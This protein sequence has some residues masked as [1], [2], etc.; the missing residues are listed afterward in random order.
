MNNLH[1]T[2]DMHSCDNDDKTNAIDD[3][4]DSDIHSLL[5]HDDENCPYAEEIKQAITESKLMCEETRIL[6]DSLKKLSENFVDTLRN[7]LKIVKRSELLIVE[8]EMLN[9]KYVNLLQKKQLYDTKYISINKSIKQ[10]PTLESSWQVLKRK[11]DNI[12]IEVRLL[13]DKKILIN[14]DK[15]HDK[16]YEDVTKLI[17]DIFVKDYYMCEDDFCGMRWIVNGEVTDIISSILK[18]KISDQFILNLKII[19]KMNIIQHKNCN[20]NNCTKTL[21]NL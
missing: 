2:I 13:V 21:S 12:V 17:I 14:I 4:T 19:K 9:S 7:M 8:Y 11:N 3:L 5:Y 16:T 15:F 18:I 1:S 6:H 10:V 20:K